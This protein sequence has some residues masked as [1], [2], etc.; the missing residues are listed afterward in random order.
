MRLTRC[1]VL[2]VVLIPLPSWAQ[3]TDNFTGTNGTAL[4]TYSANWGSFASLRI[5][6]AQIFGNG[7]N[8][9]GA[10]PTG[11]QYKGRTWANDH[12]SQLTVI[13]AITAG[14]EFW[15][16]IVRADTGGTERTGYFGGADIAN[17]GHARYSIW[18]WVANVRTQLATHASQTIA[19]NDM[20]KLSVVGSTLTLNVNSTDILT[21]SDSAITSGAAGL[22]LWGDSATTTYMD[23]FVGADISS[24]G[25]S[26]A[27][28]GTR[29][30]SLMGAGR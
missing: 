20:V 2:L 26:G 25:G 11:D 14:D 13:T 29:T 19:T 28:S 30:L 9:N 4:P 16:V 6:D 23:S 21:V 5:N 27:P 15:A 7:V 3:V 12:Y 18:K 22:Y 24:G 1:L 10:V 17:L 8:S